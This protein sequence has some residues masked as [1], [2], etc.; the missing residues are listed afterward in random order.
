M[1][2]FILFIFVGFCSSYFSGIQQCVHQSREDRGRDARWRGCVKGGFCLMNCFSKAVECQIFFRTSSPAASRGLW[3]V[4][5]SL[6]LS[7][8]CLHSDWFGSSFLL[9]SLWVFPEC[10]GAILHPQDA[11]LTNS[12]VALALSSNSPGVRNHFTEHTVK[13]FSWGRW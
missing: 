6:F 10:C 5:A 12:A 13:A 8:S 7:L 3:R 4:L 1:F 11:V 2:R 9:T